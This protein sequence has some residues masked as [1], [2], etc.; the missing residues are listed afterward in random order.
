MKNLS[1][2]AKLMLAFGVISLVTLIEAVVVWHNVLTIDNHLHR[3]VDRLI[4]QTQRINELEQTII[5]ASLETRHAMLMKT[6]AKREATFAEIGRL[7]ARA[8]ELTAELREQTTTDEGRKRLVEL[9]RAKS[10]FWEIAVSAVPLIKAGE[11]DKAVELLETKIIPA[12]NTFLAAIDHQQ[13]WQNELLARASGDSLTTGTRTEVMVLVVA[14]ITALLG[15]VIALVFA[16][17]LRNRLGGEPEDAVAAV[18]AIADGD[19]ARSVPVRAGDTTSIMAALADMR[20]RLT[21]LVSQ[22]RLGVDSVATASSEIASGNSDLSGRTEQQASSLQ[23]TASS[24]QQMTTS[25]RANAEN[26]RAANQMAAGA[27]EA[28]QRGGEVV[29]RVVSTMGEIQ[30]SSQKIA[31]IIGT[32]DGIAFQTN[33]LALN[34]AVEAARAGEAG[35]GFAVVASEVRSLASR[36]AE[37]AKEIKGLIGA[38]VEKVDNGHKLV[39]EAGRS[40]EAI[41]TQVRKVTD[42]I[43][44]ITAAT[45][46]Q[47]RGIDQV[48]SAVTQIDQGTQQNAAL[49]EQSAAAA[50]SLKQ[51]AAQLSQAVSVF[52]V[53]AADP[54]IRARAATGGPSIAPSAPAAFAP[55]ATSARVS[56]APVASSPALSAAAQPSAAQPVRAAAEPPRAKATA[57]GAPDDDWET[58]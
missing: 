58:F 28:A 42:L 24:M 5:R 23:Q 3:I 33:I 2:T 50:E 43:G 52:R 51:Q 18:K 57:S 26:A 39:T 6:E 14:A 45:E 40:M 54:A 7:K 34:A 47:T 9:D 13:A 15:I 1:L 55:A 31:D 41:V 11:I 10:A 17:H 19:L 30:Q 48:S 8:D 36:S 29:G 27:S 56:K 49:V 37:A 35:R 20:E 16:R 12:R 4:P 32:I 21:T 22:V 46:E 44:E 53:S 25:V 38:S